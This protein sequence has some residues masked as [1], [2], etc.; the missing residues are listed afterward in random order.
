[1]KIEKINDNSIKCILNKSDLQSRNIKVSELAYGSDKANILFKEMTEQ[2][3]REF[4]FQFDNSPIMIEA[5]PMSDESI[6]LIITKVEDPEELDTRFSRFS[7]DKNDNLSAGNN[8]DN[9]IA[10]ANE[11]LNLLNT[12]KEALADSNGFNASPLSNLKNLSE[13]KSVESGI[14]LENIV[15][16]FKFDKIDKIIALSK[17]LNGKYTGKNSIYKKDSD[18]YLTIYKSEHTPEEF[19]QI[20]NVI[21]EFGDRTSDSLSENYLAEHS[22]LVISDDALQ[23][24]INC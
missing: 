15:I 23:E 21:C 8:A 16:V 13:N 10:K 24:L 20:C 11:I 6:T 18:F 7:P 1:M 2:A 4:G 5:I 14:K 3:N 12:F 17:V 22:E 9:K 19:N